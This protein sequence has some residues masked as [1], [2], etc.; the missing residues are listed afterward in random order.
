M[1]H[2]S[3]NAIGV[4]GARALAQSPYM[5]DL[6]EL[7]CDLEDL[8]GEEGVCALRTSELVSPQVRAW[9]GEG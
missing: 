1:L 5:S 7:C 3:G 4:E 2:I 8:G 9:F 6:T